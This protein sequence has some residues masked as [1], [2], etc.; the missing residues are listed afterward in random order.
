MIRL[1]RREYAAALP[2]YRA[3]EAR[4]PLVGSVLL[5]RQDGAVYVDRPS[6]PTQAYVEHAF[7]FAQVLGAPSADFEAALERY[8]L[9]DK[10]AGAPKVRLYTPHLPTF[11]RDPRHDSMRSYRQRFVMD[12]ARFESGHARGE[13]P[14]ECE[15]V[16]VGDGNVEEVERAFGVTH[17]FWR[18]AADFVAGANAVAVMHRGVP[19]SICYAAGLADVEAEIDVLTVPGHQRMGLGK[20]AVARFVGRCLERGLAPL[21]DCFANNAGSM[22][23][24]RSVGFTPK[25]AP[26]PFYTINR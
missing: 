18:S 24:S 16:E 13:V 20:I 21:W 14:P 15:V 22:Q 3:S 8:L 2:L 6:A 19:A 26:Y 10:G 25:G 1:E 4:F 12:A 11:L 17:R 7:G 23:L 9:V 5:D